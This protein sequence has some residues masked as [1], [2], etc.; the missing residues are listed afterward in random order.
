MDPS[1]LEIEVRSREVWESFDLG[2]KLIQEYWNLIYKPWLIICLSWV[3]LLFLIFNQQPTIV[4]L[5]FWWTF[6]IAER[7]VLLILS[8][9]VFSNHLSTKESLYLW[10]KNLGKGIFG[11]LLFY[12]LSSIRS[13]R[14]PVEILEGSER[15]KRESRI[16][17]MLQ[18]T[19]SGM[20]YFTILFAH[21]EG[22]IYVGLFFI[23]LS[24]IP[25]ALMPESKFQLHNLDEFEL[26]MWIN[27]MM[28]G[29]YF[30]TI[31][32]FRP[33]YVAGG[34]CLYL[35]QRIVHEG[36]D[37]ELCFRSIGKRALQASALILICLLSNNRL[38]AEEI[39]HVPA[40]LEA[41]TQDIAD[42]ILASKDFEHK[43]VTTRRLKL[44]DNKDTDRNNR[45]SH[46]SN[47]SIFILFLA[48]I[49]KWVFIIFIVICF[50]TL[51]IQSHQFAKLEIKRLEE[52]R[53]DSDPTR[54]LN[55]IQQEDWP[56]DIL[57]AAQHSYAN[58]EI[59]EALSLLYRSSL[60]QMGGRYSIYFP[61]SYTEDECLDVVSKT[62]PQ[63][64]LPYFKN[65]LHCWT[66]LAYGH[67]S[68]SESHF[69]VLCEQ[70]KECFTKDE[71]ES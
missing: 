37:I 17:R 50:V 10:V 34:F 58:G 26:P 70:W 65:M 1:K 51:L 30:I 25:Q 44:F 42:D 69:H 54:K 62:A 32:I 66:Y 20:S 14:M 56:E 60:A 48:S 67:Q 12:R 71:H 28:N 23:I 5:I 4:S 11:T 13:F 6:P 29:V 3:L 15:S 57:Q 59:R 68:P 21:L 49:V 47:P 16:P 24:F 63:H 46:S 55:A 33:F 39:Q 7:I 27:W 2:T 45:T 8:R 19:N 40:G 22:L 36:W 9:A 31:I 52:E 41:F 61:G 43:K 38:E 64:L 18:G 35:R 53:L